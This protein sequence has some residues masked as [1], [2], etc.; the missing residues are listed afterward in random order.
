M[1]LNE[2]LS[3]RQKN[4]PWP[5]L[6]AVLVGLTLISYLSGLIGSRRTHIMSYN[7]CTEIHKIVDQAPSFKGGDAAVMKYYRLKILP[8]LEED[9]GIGKEIL[10]LECILLISEE[11]KVVNCDIEPKFEISVANSI[12]KSMFEMLKWEPA[13]KDGRAVCYEMFIPISFLR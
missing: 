12:A 9:K 7:N 4:I 6:L 13:Y 1:R 3:W 11:G 10:S 8:L 5:R 2:T